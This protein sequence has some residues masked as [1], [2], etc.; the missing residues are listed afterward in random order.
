MNNNW[1]Q[2]PMPD[3]PAGNNNPPRSGLL[4]DYRQQQVDQNP[5]SAQPYAQGPYGQSPQPYQES[6]AGMPVNGPGP[7]FSAGP[8]APPSGNLPQQ[9]MQR[10]PSG[11]LPPGPLQPPS[12]HLPPGPVQPPS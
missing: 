10:P 11:N 3:Q 9:G 4:R 5:P 1:N 8:M 6:P 12:G 7:Q 2:Q